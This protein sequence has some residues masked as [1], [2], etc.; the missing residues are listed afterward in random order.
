M[1]L[2][3]YILAVYA[4]MSLVSFITYGLDKRAAIKDK[5]RTPEKTLHL[6]DLFGGWP[7]AYLAMRKFR[8]KT[9]KKTFRVVYWATVVLHVIGWGVAIWLMNR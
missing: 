4:V 9:Q 3:I 2:W 5:R 1:S 8:H 6:L 7:G